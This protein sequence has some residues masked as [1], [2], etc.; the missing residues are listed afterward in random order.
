M[1]AQAVTGEW[2]SRWQGLWGQ[3][4]I[5][6]GKP[7]RSGSGEVQPSHSPA[8]SPETHNTQ[9]TSERNGS[10]RTFPLQAS[11]ASSV[12]ALSAIF[13]FRSLWWAHLGPSVRILRPTVCQKSSS[14]RAWS[15]EKGWVC[16]QWLWCSN[17]S[18]GLGWVCLKEHK[19]RKGRL[20]DKPQEYSNLNTD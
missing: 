13:S 20:Q 15:P 1:Y 12:L 9:A 3:E 7:W 8:R 14:Q 18:R 16:N 19:M 10:L 4:R 2:T 6:P 5:S 17:G 11:S